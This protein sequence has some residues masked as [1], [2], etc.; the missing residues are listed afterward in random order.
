MALGLSIFHAFYSRAN[1]T[2]FQSESFEPSFI[3]KESRGADNFLGKLPDQY[4]GFLK[5]Y[6][7]KM[8]VLLCNATLT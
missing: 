3:L 6:N 8:K 1:K 2:S 4:S 5:K 7:W